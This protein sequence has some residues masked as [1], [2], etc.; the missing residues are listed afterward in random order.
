MVEK[1]T[2]IG[3]DLGDGETITDLAVLDA[4]QMKE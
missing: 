2:F 4:N 3:Y 1:K